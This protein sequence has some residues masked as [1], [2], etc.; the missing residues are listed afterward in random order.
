MEDLE[1][2]QH[3]VR[4]YESVLSNI[5]QLFEVPEMME[6]EPLINFEKM[7]ECLKPVKILRKFYDKEKIEMMSLNVDEIINKF[8]AK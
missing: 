6:F 8:D 2:I 3:D 5:D 7:K 4:T 1:N